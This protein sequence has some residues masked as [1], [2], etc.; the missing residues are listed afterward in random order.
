MGNG[1][2]RSRGWRK[3]IFAA[4]LTHTGE[5]HSQTR[6]RTF[7][8]LL[9]HGISDKSRLILNRCLPMRNLD[10]PN[11]K[12]LQRDASVC[13]NGRSN[14]DHLE[15]GSFIRLLH[16]SVVFEDLSNV[17]PADRVPLEFD[18][19]VNSIHL[20][21]KIDAPAIDKYLAPFSLNDLI[22]KKNARVFKKIVLQIP[23]K[24]RFNVRQPASKYEGGMLM[25]RSQ[26]VM[27][28]ITNL[29]P[30]A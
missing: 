29:A 5:S 9:I 2:R 16:H 26:P 17:L 21:Q 11:S 8:S 12:F 30:V 20:K 18:Y 19:V 14:Q 27:L 24:H 6:H 23:F 22:W 25:W 13:G 15:V 7:A 10:A 1:K 28:T 3:N 4:Y